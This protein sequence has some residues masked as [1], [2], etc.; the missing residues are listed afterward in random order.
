M[1]KTKYLSPFEQGM[2]VGAKHIG[3]CQEQQCCWVNMRLVKTQY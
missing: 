1:G 3:L 2:V